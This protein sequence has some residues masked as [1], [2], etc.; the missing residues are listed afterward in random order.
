[1]KILLVDDELEFVSTLAER[2]AM[3]GY[4][5]DWTSTG[6]EAL[7]KASKENYDLAILDVKMPQIGG[8]ELRRE[9]QKK[10]PDMRFMFISGHG[11]VDDF[12]VGSEEAECY[13]IKPVSIEKLMGMIHTVMN[14]DASGDDANKD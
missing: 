6:R 12:S 8:I 13:V 5:A 3:R 10:N 4:S 7:E 9:L 1:M 2:L 11:S 14:E